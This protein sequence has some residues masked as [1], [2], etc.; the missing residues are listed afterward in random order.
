MPNASE[1]VNTIF[2]KADTYAK[3]AQSSLQGFTEALTRAIY[4]PTPITTTWASLSPPSLAG[5]PSVPSMPSIAFN[6][7][8]EQ[9]TA[10]SE[11]L[12][13]GISISTFDEQAPT[14]DLPSAPRISYGTVPIVPGIRDVSVPNAPHLDMPGLPTFLQV[15]AVTF[16]GVDLRE[17]WLTKLEDM[18]TL[19]L[20]EPTPYSYARGP[21][22]ASQ[23]LDNLRAR[24]NERIAG[25][26]GLDPAVE[27]ALWDRARS[28]ETQTALANEADIMRSSEAFGFPLPSG[29]LAVQM[30]QAR[31]TYFDKVSGLS[32]DISIKQA[33][34]EQSNARDAITAGM[35]MEGKLIDYSYQ[36]EN[37]AFESA[38]AA[39]DNA[40]QLYNASL[41]QF[42]ALLQG[43][44][45]Y[46]S[47]YKTIID[48]QLAKVEVYKA[49]LQGELAKVQINS[50]LVEQY[51]AQIGAEMSRVDIFRAQVGAAQTLV[52]L[53]QAKIGAAGE[54]IRAYVAQVNAETAKVEAY[55]A[56]IEAESKKI[57]IYKVKADAFAAKTGAQ[58]EYS[59]ALISRYSA[60]TSAKASEWD[61]Y[62]AKI[63]AESARIEALGKQSF[64]LLDGYKAGA[65]A[66]ISQAEMQTKVWETNIKQYEAG[67]N[68]ALQNAKVNNDATNANRAANLDA[69]KA[70]AQVYA[71]LVGSAY[72]MMHVGASISASGGTSVSYS[73]G[74]QV[75]SD[76]G[77]VT[78]I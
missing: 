51:K 8:A 56:G 48:G 73:Y 60:I 42:K 69:A 36:M 12:P 14:L 15:N 31:Q 33:D 21:A 76:V 61:G 55:K 38:K 59:R 74:G 67:Q 53:E 6:T 64:A 75:N 44:Q 22:Y 25:G 49:Q 2:A 40:V 70:G 20:A 9:P 41:E 23:L 13:P 28:R 34:L 35:Q 52:Q 4:A 71:Q 18:P 58:A 19:T 11:S 62:R 24:L 68:I 26:T 1:Q 47:V 3:N 10:L 30:R 72:Q 29:T 45:T 46:A 63:G 5:L 17:D 77:P 66:I 27:Q 78:S 16:G 54:Q 43:Y 32:R 7:P 37:L 65:A 39:A 50:S 57:D